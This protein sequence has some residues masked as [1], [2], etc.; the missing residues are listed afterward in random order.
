MPGTYI[1]NMNQ[2][3]PIPLVYYCN[4]TH[5]CHKLHSV[6]CFQNIY[7]TSNLFYWKWWQKRRRQ[8]ILWP[9]QHSTNASYHNSTFTFPNQPILL[10]CPS[11]CTKL[12]S[13]CLNEGKCNEIF[14]LLHNVDCILH[15]SFT[16]TCGVGCHV[17][18]NG[19]RE[20]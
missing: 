4:H 20:E 5:H 18:R 6:T 15:F 11:I 19:E 14:V 17:M 7:H 8:L 1:H 13:I 10:V 2:C 12:L 3:I 16:S 9:M